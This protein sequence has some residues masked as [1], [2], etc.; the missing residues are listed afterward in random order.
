MKIQ[1][2]LKL[3]TD[4]K[5]R[6]CQGYYSLNSCHYY[7]VCKNLSEVQFKVRAIMTEKRFCANYKPRPTIDLEFSF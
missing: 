3:F 1:E 5:L 4:T 2:Q 6:R 7:L